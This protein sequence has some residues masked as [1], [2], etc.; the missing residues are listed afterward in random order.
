MFEHVGV[1]FYDAFFGKCAELLN[2][3]GV[4]LLHFIGRESIPGITNPWIAK[5]IFPGGY[6][7]ALSE[8]L[9]AIERARL[10]V[11]DIEVLQLH[12]AETLKAWRERFLAHRDEV[13]RLYDQRFVRMWEFY[14]ACVRNRVPR[15]RHGRVSDPDGQAQRHHAGDA[16]LHR[17]RRSAVARAR[18]RS[19]AAVA[20]RR[21][22]TARRRAAR[23]ERQAE[24]VVA[25][26]SLSVRAVGNGESR[27]GDFP[28]L[29]RWTIECAC[30]ACLR[31]F[32]HGVK[33]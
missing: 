19:R 20:S 22:I 24:I 29:R 14:L 13:V 2:D 10:I 8:V 15:R 25:G 27:N 23:N 16:G 12:Y 11:T 3:D 5:Y 32:G 33:A 21:R 1:G 18:S 30:V 26:V 4:A 31:S 7:P 17:A 28:S 9:P 6:I